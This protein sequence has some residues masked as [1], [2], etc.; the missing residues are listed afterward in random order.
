MALFSQ[1]SDSLYEL[2]GSQKWAKD[3]QA[4]RNSQIRGFFQEN[5]E[6]GMV[7][8]IEFGVDDEAIFYEEGGMVRSLELCL[9][10][11]EEG[12]Y[13]KEHESIFIGNLGM[14]ELKLKRKNLMT[15]LFT[16][17][18]ETFVKFYV[19][20]AKYCILTTF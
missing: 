14:Y 6:S 20:L 9:T 18:Y 5:Q 16:S 2:K 15:I 17:D 13:L 1:N 10:V 3:T 12:F 4:N 19:H 11:M 8:S 7:S